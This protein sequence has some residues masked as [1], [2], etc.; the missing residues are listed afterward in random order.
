M[1]WLN[2]ILVAYATIASTFGCWFAVSRTRKSYWAKQFS[3]LRK[4]TV[5]ITDALA[6]LSESHS[7]LRSRVSMRDVRARKKSNGSEIPDSQTDPAG[8]KAAMRLL[9]HGKNPSKPE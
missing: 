7:R 8:Y 4:V 5:E 2:I 3:E 1:T 9:L 6:A